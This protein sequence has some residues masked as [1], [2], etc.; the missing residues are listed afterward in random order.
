MALSRLARLAL[1]L[2]MLLI[3][4]LAAGAADANSYASINRCVGTNASNPP[5]VVNLPFSYDIRHVSATLS[6][7]ISVHG[8]TQS[9]FMIYNT[10][11]GNPILQNYVS[12]TLVLDYPTV[13]LSLTGTVNG[14]ATTAAIQI[15]PPPAVS[16]FTTYLCVTVSGE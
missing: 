7:P 16:G 11:T 4:A 6:Q 5:V 12:S 1:G 15:W 3:G 8:P 2:N 14:G 9:L 10:T 13:G